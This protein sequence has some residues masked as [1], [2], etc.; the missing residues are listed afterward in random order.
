MIL[1]ISESTESLTRSEKGKVGAGGNSKARHNRSELNRSKVDGG[2]VGDD[3]VKKKVQKL[4]KSKKMVRLDFFTAGAKLAFT[5][6]R[7]AFVKAPILHYFDPERRVRIETDVSGYAIG[8]VLNQLI[9]DN[10]G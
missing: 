2:E 5:K 8:R 3:E 7:Q 1:K 9:S 4:F 6:L 10:L